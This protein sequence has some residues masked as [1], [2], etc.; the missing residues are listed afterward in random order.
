MVRCPR[1]VAEL[2]SLIL[3]LAVFGHGGV[4]RAEEA[5]AALTP[6]VLQEAVEGIY[7]DQ[8]K[9]EDLE[10]TVWLRLS[11]DVN[12]RVT[13]ALV[14]EPAGH[15]FDEAAR[16]AAFGF[17]FAPATRGGQ[18]VQARIRYPFAFKLAPEPEPSPAPVLARLSGRV[19]LDGA[20]QVGVRVTLTAAGGFL[21]TA[22][23]DISGRFTFR[24]L[25]PGLYRA[26]AALQAR[27]AGG[28][29]ELTA[30]SESEIDLSFAP[31]PAAAAPAPPV[32][33]SVRGKLSDA[34]RLQ[35]SAEAVNVIDTRRAKQQTADLGEVLART[36]GVTVRRDG[37]LGSSTRFA[38]N[39]LYDNQVRF[40][41]DGVPLDLAGYSSGIADVPVNLV[42]RVEIYRGV[43]PI[44]FGADALGGAVNLVSDQSYR[45]HLVASYQV[46]SFGTHRVSVEGRYHDAPSGLVAGGAAF[47][48]VA[49]NNYDVDVEI[50]DARGRLFAANVP[51]F[52]DRYRSYGGNVEV[53]LVDRPWARRLLL[54]GFASTYDKELQNNLV[55]TVPYGEVTYGE[56]VYGG[57]LRYEVP[58]HSKVDLETVANYAHR[59]I[60]FVD[61]GIWVYDWNGQ[62]IRER[63]VAGELSS[64]PTDQTVTQ[65]GVF[66]RVTVKWAVAPAHTIRVALTPNYNTRSGYER[67]RADPT[68]RDP[69]TARQDLGTLVSGLEYELNLF[70]ERLSNIVLLKDYLYRASVEEP[71]PG[72]VFRA[73]N[74]DSHTEGIGDELRFRFTPWLYGKASY[75][76]ATRLPTPDEVFGNGVLTLANLGLAPEVSHNVNVGPHVDLNRTP[77]GDFIVDMNAFLRHSDRLIVLLG[78]DRFS[79]YQNVYTARGLGLENALAWVSPGRWLMLNG[80]LT[81]QSVRNASSQGTFADF[82]GDRIPNRPYFFSSWGA[83]LRFSH[84][85]GPDDTVE[86]F[87]N[88]RYVH[89]FFRGWESQ[90]LRQFKQVVDA[91]LAHSVGVSWTLARDF[92]RVTSSLEVDNV[93]DAKLFDNF[94]VQRPGR[95]FYLKISGEI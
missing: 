85:P 72:N 24:G 65:N 45:N 52:H 87:Y 82:D 57:T 42:D 53:G 5:E 1:L 48:D 92:G 79:M 25:A 70:D 61:K 93:T 63:R 31:P 23:S 32:E 22:I 20:P 75:E 12:G 33:V 76:Y 7:P 46:G 14:V 94:G 83:R 28:V 51:R 69:L 6:P 38:L 86:P 4:A 15:G 47:F 41:V 84:L 44:R 16:E 62:R 30:G 74:T 10:A 95:A 66:G 64:T 18:P 36:Q 26:R 71:L 35:Q 40:F 50:P 68:S 89:E 90:G 91:Q 49:Q 27:L 29:V 13:E 17:K 11:I 8:A 54:K 34:E 43:V 73:R 78:N 80:T 19:S 77:Y 67:I 2:V 39:G 3:A 21:S 60:D 9:L 59:A 88:G 55:M 37:G 81:W 58:L 56:S